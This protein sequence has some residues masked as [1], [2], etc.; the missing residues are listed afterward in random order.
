M[1]DQDFFQGYKGDAL[2][3]L[4]KY[5]VRVWGQAIVKTSRGTFTGTVLPRAE[6]DDDQHCGEAEGDIRG[7][8][9]LPGREGIESPSGEEQPGRADADQKVRQ[10]ALERCVYRG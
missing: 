9:P 7:D 3:L 10:V 1:M 6:N 8:R 2:N 5:Q 4:K